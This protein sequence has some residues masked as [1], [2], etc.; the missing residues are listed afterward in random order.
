MIPLSVPS[1]PYSPSNCPPS[2][3]PLPPAQDCSRV[4]KSTL[5]TIELGGHNVTLACEDGWTIIQ[6]RGPRGGRRGGG[7]GGGGGDLNFDRNWAEFKRGFGDPRR[8]GEF[9]LGNDNIHL[10][11]KQVWR[12]LWLVAAVCG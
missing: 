3:F 11:T 1:A 8:G 4:L 10:I 5:L 12:I 2:P 7:G 9:W 6:R